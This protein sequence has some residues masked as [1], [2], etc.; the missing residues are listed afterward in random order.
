MKTA[1]LFL[2]VL[3]ALAASAPVAEEACTD[4][5]AALEPV[6]EAAT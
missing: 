1:T 4:C 5:R 6:V 2:T 3:A